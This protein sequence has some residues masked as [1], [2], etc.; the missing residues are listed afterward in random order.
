MTKFIVF[1][2][3]DA[4]KTDVHLFFTITNY[5]IVRS[6]S[7]PRSQGLSSLPPLVVGIETL[8]AAGHVTTQNL[9]GKKICWAGGVAEWFDC[10]CGKLCRFQNLEQS[11]PALSEFDVE[12]CCWRMLHYF[13]RL[14]NI[15]DFRSQRNSAAEWSS[16]FSTL[17]TCKTS[18]TEW[19]WNQWIS[20]LN[21]WIRR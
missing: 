10:C 5:Q 12:V 14:Q 16:N 9:G 21:L 6:R 19:K 17:H 11:L 18:R 7:Q 2:R 8:V 4:L 3:T 15:E 13:C 20:L 1:N